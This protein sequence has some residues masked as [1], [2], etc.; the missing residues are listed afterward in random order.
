MVVYRALPER[1]GPV[2]REDTQAPQ[3][4]LVSRV[5]P[6]RLAKRVAR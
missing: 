3:D 4:L 5:Y 1:Q 2:E 6:E